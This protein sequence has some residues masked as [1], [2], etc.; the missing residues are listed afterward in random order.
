MRETAVDRMPRNTCLRLRRK[1]TKRLGGDVCAMDP[2]DHTTLISFVRE[3]KATLVLHGQTCLSVR[4]EIVRRRLNFVAVVHTRRR[5]LPYVRRS[6]RWTDAICP[7]PMDVTG[8]FYPT[9][10]FTLLPVKI[11]H[12]IYAPG[13]NILGFLYILLLRRGALVV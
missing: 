4:P 5:G 10:I 6:R 9:N 8:G 12:I 7:E 1:R 2:R 11:S 3:R 13:K